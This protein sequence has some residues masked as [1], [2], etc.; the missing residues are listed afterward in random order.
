MRPK[1]NESVSNCYI[2]LMEKCWHQDPEIRPT[3]DELCE[4]FKSWRDDEQIISNLNK[5]EPN[6]VSEYIKKLDT[7]PKCS[8][9]F[10]SKLLN[11][12]NLSEP[13]NK[14]TLMNYLN[15]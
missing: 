11:L 7:T 10:T 5:F 2:E 9:Q 8:I 14:S 6:T 4:T 15:I 12:A 13:I 1:V 3:A